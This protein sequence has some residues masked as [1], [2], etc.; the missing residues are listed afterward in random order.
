MID[1][2]KAEPLDLLDFWF[3]R[4]M[5]LLTAALYAL[6]I[7]DTRDALTRIGVLLRAGLLSVVDGSSIPKK[8]DTI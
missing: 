3:V 8:L 4:M 5:L 2:A 1:L 6:P 7:L